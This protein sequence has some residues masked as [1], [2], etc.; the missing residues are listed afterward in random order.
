L[1]S[2]TGPGD[3]AMQLPKIDVGFQKI[4]AN[5]LRRVML[6]GKTNRLGLSA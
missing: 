3:E 6:T 4:T 1:P 2:S 5:Q